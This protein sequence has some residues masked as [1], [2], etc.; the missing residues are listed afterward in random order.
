[1]PP[2]LVE[3]TRA[4]FLENN[5]FVHAIK[6]TVASSSG[7]VY[8]AIT[9]HKKSSVV[10]AIFGGLYATLSMY[11]F[12]NIATLMGER[13]N[14]RSI[15]SNFA[16]AASKTDTCP[17]LPQLFSLPIESCPKIHGELIHHLNKG[18]MAAVKFMAIMLLKPL[19]LETVTSSLVFALRQGLL[20]KW[21]EKESIPLGLSI[22]APQTANEIRE[23]INDYSDRAIHG[24]INSV[25]VLIDLLIALRKAYDLYQLVL[26]LTPSTPNAELAGFIILAIAAYAALNALLNTI[27]KKYTDIL[28][29]NRQLSNQTL[30]FNME[31]AFQ[32]ACHKA[33]QHE[34]NYLKS[35]S[36]NTLKSMGPR[37]FLSMSVNAISMLFTNLMPFYILQLSILDIIQTPHLF[38]SIVK[39]E[40]LVTI[41]C[42]NF[43]QVFSY[44]SALSGLPY[45][46]AKI[47]EFIAAINQ[48]VSLLEKRDQHF[49]LTENNQVDLSC[50]ITIRYP[51]TP[52][53]FKILLN[54]FHLIFKQGTISVVIGK[55]GSGK[56]SFLQTLLGVHP[57]VTG[58]ITRPT[59][60]NIIYVPQKPAFKP[61]LNWQETIFYPRP[62]PLKQDKS[63]P[64]RIASWVKVLNLKDVQERGNQEGW[65]QHLSGGETQRLAILQALI[66]IHFLREASAKSERILLLLDESMSQLD[67]ETQKNVSQ[68]IEKAVKHYQLTTILIDHRKKSALE[69]H[70]GKESIV[71]FEQFQAIS[72][73]QNR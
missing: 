51:T 29:K 63:L 62:L 1:M 37:I 35:L 16:G 52:D 25:T 59:R 46:V 9:A 39:I 48:Y 53:N 65:L 20:Q 44:A 15:F 42:Y 24:I 38:F 21:L 18:K 5:R 10:A 34:L 26:H 12:Q 28:L 41:V 68:L 50:H 11:E 36:T 43:W 31:N 64:K 55:S 40:N 66:Q 69:K 4:S 27:A 61:A 33:T 30:S 73:S 23:I 58:E 70:Y 3:S 14:Y 56:T 47:S 8:F 22:T 17:A 7:I 6:Q 45:A 71:D 60:R 72:L 19:F 67:H 2:I 54:N 57:Y 32:I 49:T 13:E